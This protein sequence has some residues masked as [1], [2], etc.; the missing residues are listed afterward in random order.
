M[1]VFKRLFRRNKD[2]HSGFHRNLSALLAAEGIDLVID[3]GANQGQFGATV[4]AMGFPGRVLSFEPGSQSHAALSAAAA[5]NA[6]W[7]VAPRMAL[8]RAAETLTLHGFNR[9]DMNSLL[10][11]D[12]KAF[13][14]FPKLAQ[15]STEQT[16][17]ARLDSV[18]DDYAG[19]EER[20]FLKIDTQG[21]ELAVLE[22]AVGCLDR[23]AL[24][25]LEIPLETIYR[26]SPSWMDILEPV[27]AWGFRPVLTSPGYFSK[28]LC[29]QLDVDIVFIRRT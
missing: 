24:L 17:V 29:R 11:P 13:E 20:I 27:H 28:K 15:A 1:G 12:P 18:L 2:R 3:V 14:S 25:Q 21:S 6:R 9:S 23:I 4:F 19:P 7:V 8:G 5:G 10:P 26:D 16:P 22:G